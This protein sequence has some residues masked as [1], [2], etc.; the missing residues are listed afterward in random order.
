MHTYG[1]CSAAA[2][3]GVLVLNGGAV[4][5]SVAKGTFSTGTNGTP[6]ASA[7]D[8]NLGLTLS[9][10]AH[11]R[12]KRFQYMQGAVCQQGLGVTEFPRQDCSNVH[13]HEEN[14]M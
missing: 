9:A 1:P 6:S 14:V 10:P 3:V 12:Q 11:H 5:S 7:D 8:S 2:D 4:T 13:G